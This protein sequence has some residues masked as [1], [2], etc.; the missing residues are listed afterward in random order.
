MIGKVEKNTMTIT[1]EKNNLLPLT[2]RSVVWQYTGINI[3]V[4]WLGYVHQFV[5]SKYSKLSIS[6]STLVFVKVKNS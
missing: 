6:F 4:K 3:T 5:A 1:V 2:C